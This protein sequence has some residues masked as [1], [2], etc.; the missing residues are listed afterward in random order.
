MN[1]P[2]ADSNAYYAVG[3][4]YSKNVFQ[5]K[6]KFSQPIRISQIEI[7]G[8]TYARIN[9]GVLTISIKDNAGKILSDKKFDLA[10]LEDNSWITLKFDSKNLQLVKEFSV[11]ITSTAINPN[12][13]IAIW[14]TEK[15][16]EESQNLTL[17]G[18]TIL[19]SSVTQILGY[20]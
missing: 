5:E 9:Q 13:G 1:K 14:A 18:K 6:Y 20:K 17:G 2:P 4:I 7:F 19:G 16:A 3:P 11:L 10:K 15:V 8:A 12:D